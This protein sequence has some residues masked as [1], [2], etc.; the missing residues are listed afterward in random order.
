MWPGKILNVTNGVTPRRWI[1]LYN[2]IKANPE[3]EI[4]SR[5]F[6]FVANYNVKPGQHRLPNE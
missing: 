5:T 3:I 1:A 2:R 6:V 4:T